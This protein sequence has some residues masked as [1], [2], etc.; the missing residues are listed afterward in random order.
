MIMICTYPLRMCV[1]KELSR[2]KTEDRER[3]SSTVLTDRIPRRFPPRA[4][5]QREEL[6]AKIFLR[7]R[8]NNGHHNLVTLDIDLLSKTVQVSCFEWNPVS[9]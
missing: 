6:N 4:T 5:L 9:Y 8:L 7:A 3:I 2:T 1:E